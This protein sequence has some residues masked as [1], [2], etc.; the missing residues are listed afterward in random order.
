[1]H[2]GSSWSWAPTS[3][4]I[5]QDGG[6]GFVQHWWSYQNLTLFGWNLN[7]HEF[8]KLGRLLITVLPPWGWEL[9]SLVVFS[10]Y[11]WLRSC[12]LKISNCCVDAGT[13]T[14]DDIQRDEW[15]LVGVSRLHWWDIKEVSKS[16]SVTVQMGVA[17]SH[18]VSQQSCTHFSSS[19]CY[20]NGCH[21]IPPYI[22][23]TN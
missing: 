6:G 17:K 18:C 2:N 7:D 14:C 13:R 20:C 3:P 15:N 4:L 21:T 22:I 16:F 1:M 11:H 12:C 23:E 10:G 9:E 8:I 19:H 5:S